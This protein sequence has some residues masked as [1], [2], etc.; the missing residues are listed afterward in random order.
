M[1]S[2]FKKKAHTLENE[3]IFRDGFREKND[4]TQKSI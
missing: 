3:A 4:T 1:A 2:Q